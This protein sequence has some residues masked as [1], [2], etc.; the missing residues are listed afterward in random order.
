MAIRAP[1]GANKQHQY[2]NPKV[3]S[4]FSL[5]QL[6]TILLLL[7]LTQQVPKIQVMKSVTTSEAATDLI[8]NANLYLRLI[9]RP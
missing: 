5:T 2:N 9:G 7:L 8:A 1:D 4:I 6:L 3:Y